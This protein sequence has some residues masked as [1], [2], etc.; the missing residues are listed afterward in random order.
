MG[1][2][3]KYLIFI[4]TLMCSLQSWS[5]E[6]LVA[7]AANF[8]APMKKIAAAFEQDT[9]NKVNISIGSTGKFYTQIKNRGP[10]HVL[11]AADDEVPAKLEKEGLGESGSRFTYAIG[12]LV[13]WSKNSALVDNKGEILKTGTFKHISIADPKLSPY[14]FAAMETLAQLSLD[15]AITTRA[16]WGENIGQAYLFVQSQSAELGFV[17]LS[18][19]YVDGRIGEGSAWLVPESMHSPIRQDAILLSAG[20]NNPTAEDFL[21]FMKGKKARDIIKSYGYDL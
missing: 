10:Y 3:L 2:L 18:Q 13:L 17:A 8:A 21:V 9:A 6:V 1:K 7:V 4:L 5:G 14:G 11:L 12:K 19:V 15:K 16:V 20:K